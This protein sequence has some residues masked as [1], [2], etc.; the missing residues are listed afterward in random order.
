MS[1]QRE[2]V[3]T[4]SPTVVETTEAYVPATAT[5]AVDESVATTY[6]PYATRRQSSYRLMQAIYLVFGVVEALIAIRFVLRLLGANPDAGFAAF[7]YGITTPLV[8]P[9]VGLFG[10]PRSGGSVFELQSIVALIV[11]ALVAWLIGR[12]VWLMVGENRSAVTAR[13]SSVETR[14]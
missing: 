10:S 4:S 9:F 12:L 3:T 13:T 1:V 5:A 11:Y 6:D 8:A 7:I 2:V 14:G